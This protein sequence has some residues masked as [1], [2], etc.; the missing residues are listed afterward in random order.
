MYGI[1]QLSS[2]LSALLSQADAR[3]L[4]EAKAGAELEFL[5]RLAGPNGLTHSLT[6]RALA[7]SYGFDV[8]FEPNFR[9]AMFRGLSSHVV[10][11]IWDDLMIESDGTVQSENKRRTHLEGMKIHRGSNRARRLCVLLDIPYE[12]ASESSNG[13]KPPVESFPP[14]V[15]LPPL[16]DYQEQLARQ[17]QSELLSSP[18]DRRAMLALPTGGGKTRVVLDTL[19]KWTPVLE[20]SG[21]LLW[22]AQHDELCEQAIECMAQIW[23]S[24][25]RPGN[26]SLKV[27]RVW[28]GKSDEIDW[29]ADVVV[30][31]P[32]S[33]QARLLRDKDGAKRRLKIIVI[34]EAHLAKAPSYKQVFQL[35]GIAAVPVL[36]VSA[37]PAGSHDAAGALQSCFEKRLLSAPSLAPHPFE[38]LRDRGFLSEIDF[39]S[40]AGSRIFVTA[41][42]RES[43]RESFR[44]RSDADYGG[45]ILNQLGRDRDRNSIIVDRLKKL[46]LEMPT[47]CFVSSV[48]SAHALAAAMTILGRSA[49]VVDASTA[50]SLRSKVLS[51]FKLGRTQFLFNFGVLATGFDAPS[52]A[53]LLMARPTRSTV[54]LE[55]MIGRGLRGPKNGGTAKCKLLWIEDDFEN[56]EELTPQSYQRFAKLWKAR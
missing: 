50:P 1:A 42:Q 43:L 52:V 15:D 13:A 9:A 16:H 19:L 44:E 51:D 54:L 35:A 20:G 11:D 28:D 5:D 32:Q 46:P 33:L 55:Q 22:V 12:C 53:C 41:D 4:L 45:A 14:Q 48:E 37:T 18:G 23:A 38:T 24:D 39:E 31:I 40:I 7:A 30:G 47:L 10:D 21:A 49:A 34:D 27:Q 25:K 3:R 6:C 29:S 8:L 56:A 36:G 26:R 17:I 2:R